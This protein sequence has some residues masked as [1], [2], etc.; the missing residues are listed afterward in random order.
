M[1]KYLQVLFLFF[2]LGLSNWALAE[3]VDINTADAKTIAANVKGI[4]LVKATAIVN[5]REKNGVFNSVDE[6]TQIRGIGPKIVEKNRHNL[7]I[8]KQ[9]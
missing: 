6:L 9:E 4:G 1:K 2:T 7:I 8:V 5:Y 3:S